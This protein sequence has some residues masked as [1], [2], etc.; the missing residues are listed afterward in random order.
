MI[1]KNFFKVIMFIL[2]S[3]WGSALIYADSAE[4]LPKGR[5]N[6]NTSGTYYLPVEHRYDP[7]GD[8]EDI[9]TNFNALLDGDV[10][11][12]L[13]DVEAGFGM[14]SGS[15]NIGRSYVDF[16]LQYSEINFSFL[17]GMTSKLSI[18]INVPYYWARNK[19][20]AYIDSNNATVGKSATG[21]GF[22]APLVPLAGGGPFGDAE[23]LNTEDVKQILSGGLDVNG[24]G[25]VDIP[26]YG[27]KR[28]RTWHGEGIGDMQVGFKY[29]YLNTRNWRLAFTGGSFLP[30]GQVDDQ[31]NLV[32]YRVWGTGTF[33]PFIYLHNDFKGLKNHVLNSTLKYT[34]FLPHRIEQRVLSD[35]NQPLSVD[36]E[37]VKRVWAPE[38]QIEMGDTYS[39]V[40]GFAF[41]L[42]YNFTGKYKNN[43]ISGDGDYAYEA[44][45]KETRWES[46][47]V[48]AGFSYSTIPQFLEKKF[49]I[50]LNCDVKYSYKFAGRNNSNK[51]QYIS[52]GLSLYF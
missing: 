51:S 40:K 24:D 50:P 11:S 52:F 9:A 15:A 20:K 48:C 26:G 27:Y 17:Y 33:A 12:G 16:E 18:G 38:V 34:Y 31:D 35:V 19:V 4:V 46:H 36:K 32:D 13:K 5:F 6:L 3:H 42:L 45:E 14:P 22:G 21:A 37:K 30:T 43:H 7:D 29:Q 47:N 49:P 39:P 23:P 8:V 28:F 44:L 41:S 10:F 25:T 1:K 2:C